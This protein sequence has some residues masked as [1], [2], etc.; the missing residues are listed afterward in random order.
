MHQKIVL[1]CV[2]KVCN[3]IGLYSTEQCNAQVT[4]ASNYKRILNVLKAH[5][6]LVLE[7][8]I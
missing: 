6:Y 4:M 1:V 8:K 3:V 2:A 7:A 5:R